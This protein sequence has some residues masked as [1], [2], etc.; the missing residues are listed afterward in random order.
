M[1]RYIIDYFHQIYQSR[2][3]S[4]LIWSVMIF[5]HVLFL[6]NMHKIVTIV[7]TLYI[8][9]YVLRHLQVGIQPQSDQTFCTFHV[10]QFP[11]RDIYECIYEQT[12]WEITRS[13]I[14]VTRK[15]G[16]SFQSLVIKL[17][18][19]FYLM[20]FMLAKIFKQINTLVENSGR[21]IS[22]A[23]FNRHVIMQAAS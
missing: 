18:V 11:K 6:L 15:N 19:K 2:I 9:K 13:V 21:I 10:N 4:L 12:H 14:N 23:M 17:W 7:T 8:I 3:C 16:Y 20:S 1:I 5:V 22:N